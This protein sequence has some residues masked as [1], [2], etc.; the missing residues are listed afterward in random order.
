M[1]AGSLIDIHLSSAN[2]DSRAVGRLPLTL[3]PGRE[4]AEGG[5]AAA[6]SF[7]DGPHKCPGANIAVLEADILLH[8][9]FALPGVTMDTPPRVGFKADIA[10]YELRG[11]TVSVG[12]G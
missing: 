6:L 3:R 9:L 8:R 5:G 4:I 10:G 1:P 11:L 2:V 12:S 7:G